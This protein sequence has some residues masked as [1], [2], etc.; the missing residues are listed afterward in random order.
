MQRRTYLLPP[1]PRSD[2][3]SICRS[4]ARSLAFACL[5][6]YQV[7]EDEGAIYLN[8]RTTGN[9]VKMD[10]TGK[11]EWVL[12]GDWGE[13]EIVDMEGK[14]LPA[15][16]SY[17][18]GQHNGEWFGEDTI[19]MFDNGFNDTSTEFG[20]DGTSRLLGVRVDVPVRRAQIIFELQL[21]SHTPI[22]G[23]CDQLPSRNLLS[24]EWPVL[25]YYDTYDQR[26]FEVDRET[27]ALAWELRIFGANYT[28]WRGENQTDDFVD[29]KAEPWTTEGEEG[30][31]KSRQNC[32]P[33]Y[34]GVDADVGQPPP[35]WFA[36]SVE[37]IYARPLIY[38]A[39]CVRLGDGETKS[40]A[41]T[42]HNTFKVTYLRPGYIDVAQRGVV[43]KPLYSGTFDFERFWLPTRL[44]ITL[45]GVDVSAP[46][47][48]SVT[49][50]WGDV[51]THEVM[52][53]DAKL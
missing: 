47:S 22:F 40:L 32:E 21:E 1:S 30:R 19:F 3:P 6:P 50:E 13:F 36:Y 25:S 12:G 48:F 14:V 52:C 4:L 42:T 11:V 24:C 28:C 45:S 18:Y 2:A 16:S 8:A 49:N 27:K 7:I 38:L 9:I 34:R 31:T 10:M 46:L 15:G 43:D 39:S 17:W 5:L 33:V 20:R 51:A 37:R 53:S 44:N 29:D 41:F 26:F 35:G 23:D